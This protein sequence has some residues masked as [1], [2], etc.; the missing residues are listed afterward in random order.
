MIEMRS[1]RVSYKKF[2]CR[3]VSPHLA[4]ST[5]ANVGPNLGRVYLNAGMTRTNTA[6]SYN[7]CSAHE[8]EGILPLL[9]RQHLAVPRPSA[10]C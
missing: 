8:R 3:K 10:T 6:C 2:P 5:L 4:S 9:S 7:H 1:P